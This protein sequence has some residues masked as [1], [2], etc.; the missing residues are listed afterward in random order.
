VLKLTN[1]FKLEPS[2]VKILCN[3]ITNR[4]FKFFDGSKYYPTYAGI[5][6]RSSL[7]PLLF[8]LY[9]NDISSAINVP[10]ILYADDLILYTD[11]T[12]CNSI[13]SQWESCFSNVC[14]WCENNEMKVNFDETKLM[15]FHKEKDSTV[16]AVRD[17]VVLGQTIERV[18]EF[19]YLGL[20]LDP[21]LNFNKHFD[22]VM[23]KV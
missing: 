12:D 11:G 1:N 15:I 10:F 22:Y 13:L 23:S 17:C 4:Q 6:Q 5:G 18:F 8:S 7:G 21:H 16:G 19:K 2:L 20:L 3:N 14:L 9:V